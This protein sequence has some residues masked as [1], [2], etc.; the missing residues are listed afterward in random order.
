MVF[1]AVL[2]ERDLD[3]VAERMNQFEVLLTAVVTGPLVSPAI[4]SIVARTAD[5]PIVG[6]ADLVAS[7]ARLRDGGLLLRMAGTSV[8]HVGRVL[9]DYLAFLSPLVGDD[10]WSR[11]W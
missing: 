3:S 2:L 9:R 6:R 11:K 8:E 7:A 10:L 1:D 4:E 5:E